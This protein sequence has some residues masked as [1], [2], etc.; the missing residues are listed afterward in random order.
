MKIGIIGTPLSGKSTVFELLTNVA[1]T[2]GNQANTGIAKVVDP[3]VA[4]LEKIVKPK[5]TMYASIEFVDIAGFAS[6]QKGRDFLNAVRDVDALVQ[7]VRTF[8][9][10]HVPTIDGNIDPMRDLQ[11]I[12]SELLLTDWSL[13]ENRLERLAK[14]KN[15]NP[16]AAKEIAV[17]EKCKAALE[18]DLPLRTLEL[19]EEEDKLIR[20]YDFFT[21]KPLIIVANVGDDEMRQKEYKGQQELEEWANERNI[22]IVIVSAEM[23][24]EISQLDEEDKALFMED[25]GIEESGIERLSR[26]AYNHLGL[27]SYFTVGEVEVRVW[28]IKKGTNAREGAGKIHSDIERGF[29]RAEVVAYDD[30]VEHG[31]MAKVK[32]KGLFRLEGKDYIIKDGDIIT[33]RFNV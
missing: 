11:E 22:P 33:F 18:G 28:T 20:G 16:N 9:N 2:S 31:S 14:E 13:L 12:Q 25:M 29:I 27:V 5:R 6:G 19:T 3:R 24:R 21:R 7:V 8:E 32:E 17:L 26:V 15:K 30:F 4:N 10:D 1:A 23:E